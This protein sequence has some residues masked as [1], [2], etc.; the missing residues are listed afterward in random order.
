MRRYEMA[1]K[2]GVREKL[3]SRFV[4][5]TTWKR[6]AAIVMAIV[7]IVTLLPVIPSAKDVSAK[8]VSSYP[9][10]VD[11][12][13]IDRTTK[14]SP[15]G[16]TVNNG[17]QFYIVATIKD[18]EGTI[19]GYG[20]E[21]VY[22]VSEYYENSN[23]A[24]H[25]SGGVVT[26]PEFYDISSSPEMDYNS[27]PFGWKGIVPFTYDTS[28][29]TISVRMYRGQ[30]NPMSKYKYAELVN[31]QYTGR[32]DVFDGYAFCPDKSST[33]AESA[34]LGIYQDPGQEFD[35]RITASPE[36]TTIPTTE[37]Y[38]VW[39]TVSHATTGETYYFAPF[40]L[41]GNKV[42]DNIV[43]EW[44]DGNG[45]VIANEKY[46]GNETGVV[47]KVLKMKNSYDTTE[48]AFSAAKNDPGKYDQIAEGDLINGYTVSYKSLKTEE[49][50]QTYVT[51]HVYEIALTKAAVTDDYDLFTTLGDAI[52]Y[53]IVANSVN[54]TGHSQSNMAAKVYVGD[55]SSLD[56]NL[57]GDP[58]G[59]APGT[60][61]VGEQTGLKISDS[62]T[63]VAV[64]IGGNATEA[65]TIESTVKIDKNKDE[66]N[67]QVQDMIDYI[68]MVSNDMATKPATIHPVAT[69]GGKKL[70]IDTRGMN[71][72]GT[73][74]V[75]AD[76]YLDVFAESIDDGNGLTI[77]KEPGQLIVFNFK[78]TTTVP[79]I[80]TYQVDDGNQQVV[81]NLN[82]VKQLTSMNKAGGVFINPNADSSMQA[83]SVSCG[84]VA[85]A[86]EVR[87]GEGGEFHFVYKGIS[88]NN[89]AKIVAR[90]LVD[91]VG[92]SKDQ[93]FKFGIQKWNGTTKAFEDLMVLADPTDASS[94]LVPLTVEN[95]LASIS[96]PV[97]DMDEGVNYYRIYEIGKSAGTV[98]SFKDNTQ[99]YFAKITATVKKDTQGAVIATIPGTVSYYGTFDTTSGLES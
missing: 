35:V 72:N 93:K 29:H 33:G 64:V 54:Q 4:S 55:G 1:D 87:L 14:K 41:Y 65:N 85:T 68:S 50:P 56:P 60:M 89:Q 21:G 13:D 20:Y 94:A 6:F 66:V 39:A 63:G 70:V 34:T 83:G 78:N 58:R 57:S 9:V 5:K 25:K 98:G 99:E 42:Q 32:T 36:G 15:S 24:Y 74:Y 97:T 48:A 12:Y 47:I 16:L 71:P 90:K 3:K 81:W 19:V 88:K 49:D 76:Q 59:S 84:W 92:A 67:A 8:E 52:N 69:N 53:G 31:T 22:Y 61:L 10:A 82:S 38:Y 2:K 18:S 80:S 30:F 75:D 37:N 40:S 11:F 86:G 79:M 46:T 73:I 23:S 45:N 27:W 62:G 43:T 96:I 26:I 77:Y 7:M 91:N 28:L 44:R 95:N 51:R 17:D